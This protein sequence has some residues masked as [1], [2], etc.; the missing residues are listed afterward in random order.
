MASPLSAS[1]A[2]RGTYDEAMLREG[3]AKLAAYAEVK[4][5]TVLAKAWQ[6]EGGDRSR[7]LQTRWFYGGLDGT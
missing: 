6:R 4:A 3:A 1:S 7:P 2:R 5:A